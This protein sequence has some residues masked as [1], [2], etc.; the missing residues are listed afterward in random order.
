MSKRHSFTLIELLVVI[1]I[2]AILAAML[3][4]ALSKAREKARATACLNNFKQLGLA[5]TQYVMDNEDWYCGEYNTPGGWTTSNASFM[6][7]Y[8]RPS[9]L[10]TYLG[11]DKC[12]YLG[13]TDG[14]GKK[15]DYMCPSMPM[16]Q[17]G[18]I[19]RSIS[20]SYWQYVMG[21]KVSWQPNGGVNVV[22][23]ANPSATAL[24]GEVETYK[25]CQYF[26]YDSVDND[27]ANGRKIVARH[28]NTANFVMYD[29]SIKIIH[30]SKI[31]FA[32]KNAIFNYTIFWYGW[33]INSSWLSESNYNL[34]L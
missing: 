27:S 28:N 11:G 14:N 10:L 29:G 33:N 31:P 15:S 16:E 5:N 8:N 12:Q 2:I 21:H 19:G 6:G 9:V 34:T 4:P 32:S 30:E 17:N 7:A 3:L 26:N 20:M 1:A 25:T 24:I 22:K 18:E 23:L 13:A